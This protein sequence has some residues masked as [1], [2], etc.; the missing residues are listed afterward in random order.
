MFCPP[1]LFSTDYSTGMAGLTITSVLWG[2]WMKT[3]EAIAYPRCCMKQDR[4]LCTSLQITAPHSIELAHGFQVTTCVLM[5]MA[6]KLF[7]RF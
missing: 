1:E 3:V 2:M 5:T 4:S 7:L 6:S